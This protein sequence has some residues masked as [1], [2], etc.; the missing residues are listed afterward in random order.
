VVCD[1]TGLCD[2]VR[3]PLVITPRPDKPVITPPTV[4]PVLE[5]S[6]LTICTTITDPDVGDT[7]SA[8]SCATPRNG[9]VNTP[10]IVGNQVCI[11]YT[12][13]A[14]FNGRDTVC[15]VV[16][17]Q[18]GLCDTMRVPLVV[19]PRPDKPVV[20]I[21]PPPAVED[22]TIIVCVNITDPD[23]GDT[24]N[25]TTCGTPRGTVTT[26]V[27]NSTT[28]HQV[29]LTYTPNANYNGPDTLCVIVCDQTG[30]C[31]TVKT[32]IIVQSRNDAPVVRDTAI[33]TPG[34]TPRTYCLPISD[35]DATDTHSVTA[36]TTPARGTATATVNNTTHEVC[37]SYTS[38]ANFV[39]QDTACFI[40]CDNGSPS[41]C[42]TV[43]LAFSVGSS[44]RK[45]TA[46]S[47]INNTLKN[48]AVTG[49]VKTN[50][51]DPDAGQ[52]LTVNTTPVVAPVN[53]AITLASNGSYTYTPNATFV[54][55]E[56]IK[57]SVCD[58]GTPSLCD[59]TTL[60]IE[61]RDPNPTTPSVVANDDNTTALQNI[62]LVINV[63]SNDYVVQGGTLGNPTIVPN[64]SV[65]GTAS[66]DPISGI[67][68]FTPTPGF[69]GNASFRYAVCT[70]TTPVACD[71]ATVNV[72]VITDP[73][74]VNQAPVA[75]NDAV[76]TT[77]GTPV[78]GNLKTNDSDPNGD[79]LD[80]QVQTNPT[81][82]TVTI[83]PDGTF[84]YTPNAGVTGV[85]SFVYK[86]CD[87][88][89]PSLCSTAKAYVD[90]R[91]A[92][93]VV[94]NLPP[95]ATNDNP[96]TA[97]N[98]PVTINVKANDYDPNGQPLGN[99]TIVGTPTGGTVVVNP[100]GT[101]T[102]TPTPGFTGT[103]TFKYQVCDNGLPN[104][105]ATADVNVTV[106]PPVVTNV[107]PRAVNDA[108]TTPR[109]T[110]VTGNASSNDSDQNAGQILSYSM[111]TPPTN[112]TTSML[113]N[114]KFTY[115]PNPTF[116]GRDSF[117]YVVCDNDAISLCA[118]AWVFVE[119]TAPTV[120]QNVAPNAVDDNSTT[121][122]NTP[123]SINVKANDYDPNT[124]QTLSAPTI[125]GTPSNGTATVQ[126]DGTIVFTPTPGFTGTASFRYAVCDN[127]SSSLCDTATVTIAVNASGARNG[128]NIAP[129]AVDDANTTIKNTNV[130]GNVSTNDNDLNVGQNLLFGLVT[131]PVHGTVTLNANG[132]YTY[133]PDVGFTGNDLFTYQVCD[134]G[135][136]VLCDSATVYLT[137]FDF[138]CLTL[139][140]KVLLEGPLDTLTG[141]MRTTLNTR[142]LLPGQTPIG[143]FAMATP[144]G[145]PYNRAP[146]NYAGTE[147]RTTY[148]S[149]V[150]DWV[151]VTLRTDAVS[152]SSVIFKA[153]AL[154]HKDGQVEFI[155]PCIS[156]SAATSY[157]VVIEHR[158]HMGVM[159]SAALTPVNK[160]ITVD[161]TAANSFILTNPPSSGQKLLNGKYAMY[162]AE[163]SKSTQLTNFDINF[164]DNNKW[165][166]ETGVFDQ[167]RDCDHNMDADV[168]FQDNNLWRKNTGRYSGVP[169]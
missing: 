19:T 68:T 143:Q 15:L 62:P 144:A 107:A 2:T 139:N 83:A 80:Y 53:G 95:V 154:L 105:C 79:A 114:G 146:W 35:P 159:T 130:A 99:P 89:T 141:Q 165:R 50:D 27:N 5:D 28:P 63:K 70:T 108:T 78:S 10:T 110:S 52:T 11:R 153:A 136:P 64:T 92:T 168:N 138:P 57:Y 133:R 100:D 161:F 137:V 54:G 60:V 24:H 90:V 152:A 55:T 120:N 117:R 45:P 123:V 124:D 102:F 167:Y 126:P 158:N 7:F 157:Y 119:V 106:T 129:T 51:S 101:V 76:V 59:T 21:T 17:D 44:N 82:G 86:V 166:T 48:M 72:R 66:V 49:N 43:K 169:H 29:C 34:N 12:P 128:N 85:D 94:T 67:V 42:D 121:T 140:L 132:S 127:G 36:C 18:T 41:K 81:R 97:Q 69:T 32:P 115:T 13:T 142:G 156:L 25:V 23:A 65:G 61:V 98:T 47:D 14:N 73:T 93:P 26:T 30:L 1:Q 131:S 8:T 151:Y 134:N 75:V 37:I 20:I 150:V 148:A 164:Q 56:T 162:A 163:S 71:S 88:A 40:V 118:S 4:V 96:V 145:Q 9:T 147:T 91:P 46:V 103:G 104:L 38:P 16:C 3:I 112:G 84:T 74:L 122:A 77:A 135:S 111:T 125:V 31:D 113:T 22:S 149:T 160:T 116:V 109:A 58:N 87:N 155:S 39:G 6:L 33:V